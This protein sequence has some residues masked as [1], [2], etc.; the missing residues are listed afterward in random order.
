MKKS[1]F[2]LVI[3]LVGSIALAGNGFKATIQQE[4][5]E[6]CTI[7]F[8][9]TDWSLRNVTLSG[10][11]FQQIVFDGSAMTQKK[12]WAELPFIS[13]AIQLPA[14]KNVSLKVVASE[15]TDVPLTYPLVP[16]R[17]TIYRN[18]DPSKI[19]FEID[20][21]SI[22]DE[23]YPTD[24]ALMEQ[25]YIIRDVR[26]TTVRVFPFQ[27]NA[28][29]QTLR[30]FSK[31]TVELTINDSPAIN[32]I[33]HEVKSISR[34]AIGMY[35]NIFLN[36]DAAKLSSNLISMDE[37]GDILVITTSDYMSTMAPYIQWKRE[38]GYNV[39]TETVAK[40]T[41]IKTNIQNAYNNNPKLMYVQIA[42]DWADIKSP[43][44]SAE[45]APTDPAMGCV[46]GNDKYPDI[47]VGRF[48][49]ANT[50]DLKVQINK[51]IN[52]EK[53]PDMSAG[54][55]ETFIGIG[56]GEGYSYGYY[57][58]DDSELDYDHIK[59]IYNNK[60]HPNLGYQTHRENYDYG[61]EPSSATLASYI[62]AGASTIAYCGHGDVTEWVTTG[63]NNSQVNASTN[64]DK[65]PFIVSVACVNGEF[66]NSSKVCFAEAWLRKSNGGAVVM[67]GSTINQPWTPPQRGQDYFY[68]ILG[69]GYNY[70]NFANQTGYN[71]S[72]QR[73]HWGC[74]AVNSS[75]LM[76][77]ESSQ[78][79]DI[80]TV[81]T[82]TTF[83]DAALQLRTK[84]PD[85]LVLSNEMV[86]PGTAFAG[87][88]T[89][90]GTPLANV[91][92][93][94]S[95]NGTYFSGLTDGSGNYSIQ[96]TFTSDSVLLVATA[97]NT[98]TIY[99]SVLCASA[100]D[101]P[102]N[103]TAT[104]NNVTNVDLNWT[105]PISGTVTGY[106][107]Y[108]NNIFVATVTT[109]SYQHTNL[110]N[111]TYN[112]CVAAIFGGEGE[113]L[114]KSCATV[115][116]NDGTNHDCDGVSNLTA[117][118]NSN[119]ATLTWQAPSDGKIFDDVEGH[120]SFAI[121]SAGAV[122]WSAID[123][124]QK[125]TYSFS[126]YSTFTNAGS[127]MGYIILDP[128]QIISDGGTTL[129]QD[130]LTAHSGDKF[131]AFFAATN[132]VTNDDWLISPQLNYSAP[133]TF[134]FYARGSHN[135]QYV[136]SF[137]VAYSTS[138]N[139][140]SDFNTVVGTVSSV[141]FSWTKYS[142]TI[143]ATAKYV[144][145]HYN[146]NDQFYL[147][148]DDITIES[149]SPLISYYQVYCNNTPTSTTTS[150]SLNV[151]NLAA[152]NY[153]YC[154][155]TYYEDGCSSLPE[156]TTFS[157]IPE[158]NQYTITASVSFG[159]SI[160]PSGTT[161]VTEGGSQTYYITPNSNYLLKDVK[162]DNVSKG[163]ISTYTFSNVTANHTIYAD[164]EVQANAIANNT[165]ASFTLYPNPVDDVLN[166]I[167]EG[168]GEIEILNFIGQT[169]YN[170]KIT[171][172]ETSIDTKSFSSG[173]YFIRLKENG[174]STT[175]KFIK[176]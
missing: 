109:T 110:P 132:S 8:S 68:D 58:G 34:D 127:K 65:L 9:L 103:L 158:P 108:C 3:L 22:K 119:N 163:A 36:F 148:V 25:P 175:K 66:H 13:A 88:A 102:T 114:V 78:S 5:K 145:I 144:A 139:S 63:Y 67:W 147:C 82:W 38:K 42:G 64:G 41:N 24:L 37:Y 12:G 16:S 27:Y 28:V 156:C 149:T 142:Y 150:T 23:F 11:K 99:K 140:K 169:I 120:T 107:V 26:G 55:R 91:Q 97:F 59:N 98:T 143:P 50:S 168:I 77:K 20:K 6:G 94:I 44:T 134:S 113:C 73:T 2:T 33:T 136:E 35:K 100:C 72:E 76:L 112:Y 123:G 121:N 171:N 29:N 174:F 159:G 151:N 80:E 45:S 133:I 135:Q 60:L 152:G 170:Q 10:Q 79:E 54:W 105:A 129:A 18:Q 137:E 125:T 75:N 19:A 39:T 46:S 160:T 124:D 122:G 92:I 165:N 161:I 61:S 116:V 21:E 176:K 131:F 104:I 128:T 86:V 49:C 17:G 43:T 56:S 57:I 173:V 32:P 117:T 155:E 166:L 115:T 167:S 101:G 172:K 126:G 154:I 111:G 30:V 7:D 31:V 70:D 1:I 52:Y 96:H 51:A 71:T 69:G 74:I 48:S 90:N 40:G 47:S 93:C 157:I 146:A 162:V 118:V 81:Q 84:Q 153:E 164:F 89:V 130:G 15:Y 62:N 106:N 4:K 85:A 141:P 53:N 83:G 14:D 138:G 87:I 95:Q